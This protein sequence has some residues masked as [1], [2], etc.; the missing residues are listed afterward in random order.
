MSRVRLVGGR[1]DGDEGNASCLPPF[2]WAFPCDKSAPC[3]PTR[4]CAT[5]AVHWAVL[6]FGQWHCA[7]DR[8]WEP[9]RR[10]RLEGDTYIYVHA[11]LDL[12]DHELPAARR[13]LPAGALGSEAAAA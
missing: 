11:D 13:E 1:F 10:D 4:C 8:A 7:R 6:A 9:Y 5:S 12:G 3:T 2:L